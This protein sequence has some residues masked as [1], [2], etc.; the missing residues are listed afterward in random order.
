MSNAAPQQD[1]QAVARVNIDQLPAALRE[2]A[3]SLATSIDLSDSQQVLQYGI[4]A[5]NNIATFSES[6]LTKVRTKDTGYVGE[7]LMDLG[8]RVK[9]LKADQLGRKSLPLIGRLFNS[10][11]RFIQRYEKISTHIDRISDQLD[12]AKMQLLKDV[13]MLDTLYD[14]N[15][16]YLGDLEVYI[17]A[18]ELKLQAIR[19]SELPQMEEAAAQS[20]DGAQIQQLHDYKQL[21]HRFE[22]KIY[23]LRLSRTIALQT[24]PQIRLIQ[25]NDQLLVEKIQSSLLNTIPLWKNQVVIAISIFRQNKALQLQKEVTQTTNDL[26]SQN[27]EMLKQS[28]IETARENERGIVEVE[29]LKKV[30]QNLISTIEETLAIQQD[31]KNQRRQAET[32]LLKIEQE[33]RERLMALKAPEQN[34]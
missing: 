3:T 32:E 2:K 9:D 21:V 28:S 29:T 23:D 22:K 10:L 4:G 27:A 6:V 26:L 13:A 14:K 12:K 24:A 30:N 5:Q 1:Q 33:L 31:G 8:Q 34:A 17:A 11:Q 20:G 16:E 18:G 15:L 25:N 7:S 19:Q